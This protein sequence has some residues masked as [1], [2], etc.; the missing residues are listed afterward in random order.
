MLVVLSD[1]HFTDETLARE[2]GSGGTASEQWNV[3]A[4]AFSYLAD[5]LRAVIANRGRTDIRDVRVLVLGDAFDLLRSAEWQKPGPAP[6]GAP[7]AALEARACRILEGICAANAEALAAIR[8][9]RHQ[10]DLLPQRVSI[11]YVPGNHDRLVNLFPATRR[12]AAEALD[13][14]EPAGDPAGPFRNEYCC[15]EHGVLARHG[16][17]FDALNWG[18]A[19]ELAG[20]GEAVVVRLFNEFP[21]RV[22]ARLDP[23]DAGL[24]PLFAKLEELD[25]VRPL[26]A[27]PRWFQGVLAGIEQEAVRA[28]VRAAWAETAAGFI[29]DGFVRSRMSTWNP[30]RPANL[31]ARLIR[32]PW[33]LAE[34]LCRLGYLRWK[35]E[36][37]DAKYARAAAADEA[38]GCGGPIDHVVYGHTHVARQALLDVRAGRRL[39]YFNTGTWRKVVSPAEFGDERA[40]RFAAWQVL[41]Y[42]VLYRPEENRGYRF[43]M[44]AGL[45]G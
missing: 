24:A 36:S 18:G 1:I 8:D 22:R 42:L 23:A 17:Q 25:H 45:R 20:L 4:R 35:V 16:Q 6:W 9:L 38:L 11:H 10:L 39:M 19:P 31:A 33:G 40:R 41:S 26:W 12:K 13:L 7:D 32:T 5:D 28:E 3:P 44:W 43:E 29:E 2:A 34:R 14:G 21:R 15:P 30:L 27:V 37:A